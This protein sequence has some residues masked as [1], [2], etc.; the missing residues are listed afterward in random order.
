[1]ETRIFHGFVD[2]INQNIRRLHFRPKVPWETYDVSVTTTQSWL[3]L[4]E[5]WSVTVRVSGKCWRC[6]NSTFFLRLK[7]SGNLYVLTPVLCPEYWPQ[8]KP[9]HIFCTAQRCGKFVIGVTTSYLAR[10]AVCVPSQGAA[11]TSDS[12]ETVERTATLAFKIN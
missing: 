12:I 7:S 1:M 9:A 5:R 3:T 4:S 6:K 10:G 2:P 11:F 8:P